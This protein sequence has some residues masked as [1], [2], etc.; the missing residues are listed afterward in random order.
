MEA[1]PKDHLETARHLLR[2]LLLE[3]AVESCL[4]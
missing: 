4:G 3:V 2:V 1:Q